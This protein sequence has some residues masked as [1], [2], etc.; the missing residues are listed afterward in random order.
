MSTSKPK[1]Q[2]QLQVQVRFET[3]RLSPEYLATAYEAVV[4]CIR[5]TPSHPASTPHV[6]SN[7]PLPP[8]GDHH[9]CS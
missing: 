8:L 2:R 5:R 3:S 7:R 9:E 6:R 4:P 1:H